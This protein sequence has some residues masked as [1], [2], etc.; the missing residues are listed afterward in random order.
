MFEKFNKISFEEY[1]INPLYCVS[2]PGY[3]WQY[4]MKH[5]DIKIQTLQ[6][7]DLIL[8]LEDNI[9]GGISSIMGDRYMQ[10]DGN[11]KILYLDANSL[12]GWAMSEHLPYDEIKF[13]R[14]VNLEGI[15]DTPDDIDFGY[16]I[17][18]DLKYPDNIKYRTKTFLFAF[19]NKKIILDEISDCMKEIKPDTY[20]QTKNLICHWF[21]KKYF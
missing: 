5:T 11:K 7:K 8:T 20:T 6:D 14:N 1:G 12:Y 13:D 16:F 4:G 3:T 19:Q 21:D 2:L 18:V 17:K 9:R 10:S 15:L